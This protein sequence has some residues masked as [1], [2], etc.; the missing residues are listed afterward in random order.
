MNDVAVNAVQ[1]LLANGEELCIMPQ[2][3]IEFWAAATRPANVNGLGLSLAQAIAELSALKEIFALQPD[4]PAVFSEWEKL[5]IEKQVIGKQA[6]DTRHKALARRIDA[7]VKPGLR[8]A[9]VEASLAINTVS[10]L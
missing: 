8:N 7:I 3:L 2:N 5:V 4:T 6:H 1:L 10:E 9:S